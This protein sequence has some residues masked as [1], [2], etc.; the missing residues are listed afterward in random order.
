[1]DT[2][3][4]GDTSVLVLLEGEE[5]LSFI[6]GRDIP[7]RAVRQRRDSIQTKLEK[8][9][10]LLRCFQ[11]ERDLGKRRIAAKINLVFGKASQCSAPQ[12]SI[13]NISWIAR[14]S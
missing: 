7:H 11:G 1:M 2:S 13:K 12:P 4:L 14:L 5:G 10:L 9:A 3:A 6:P 8:Y